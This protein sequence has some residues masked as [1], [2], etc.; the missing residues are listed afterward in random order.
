MTLVSIH[1]AGWAL[2]LHVVL[3][4]FAIMVFPLQFQFALQLSHQLGGQHKILFDQLLRL[5][6]LLLSDIFSQ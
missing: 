5:D 4:V 1:A 3:C 6:D 2:L